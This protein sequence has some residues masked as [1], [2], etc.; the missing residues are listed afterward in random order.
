MPA[1]NA[2][3]YTFLNRRVADCA[4]PAQMLRSI[5][6]ETSMIRRWNLGLHF[7]SGLTVAHK[8]P[9][10]MCLF[11]SS[12][13][14]FCTVVH[15]H[16]G[17]VHRHCGLQFPRRDGYPVIGNLLLLRLTATPPIRPNTRA[18]LFHGALRRAIDGRPAVRPAPVQRRRW[19]TTARWLRAAAGAHRQRPA[20]SAVL[21]RFADVAAGEPCVPSGGRQAPSF[22]AAPR[23][24]SFP[25][26]IEGNGGQ[27]PA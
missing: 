2:M 5:H 12:R 18:G 16:L 25:V 20:R 24:W 17:D 1:T 13:R 26:G 21:L 3:S 15:S 8:V 27:T 7:I 9:G 19:A 10:L 11:T 4:D 6:W 23:S 14:C 22:P